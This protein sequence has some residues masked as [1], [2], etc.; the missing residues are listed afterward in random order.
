MD[1]GLKY[2]TPIFYF[3]ES[4]SNL[5]IV[6]RLDCSWGATINQNGSD[7]LGLQAPGAHTMETKDSWETPKR[8]AVAHL[9][10]GST[11]FQMGLSATD[12]CWWRCTW[13][14]P[15]E[16]GSFFAVWSCSLPPLIPPSLTHDLGGWQGNE[17]ICEFTPTFHYTG[18]RTEWSF[19]WANP[20][21]KIWVTF[22]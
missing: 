18:Q 13:T 22:L 4:L 19:Y 12:G 21:G 6:I 20:E 17:G 1:A 16:K 9:H 2:A 11:A 5:Q 7:I 10:A 15:T 8:D 3:G 14:E